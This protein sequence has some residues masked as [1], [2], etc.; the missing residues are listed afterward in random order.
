MVFLVGFLSWYTS[1]GIEANINGMVHPAYRKQGIFREILKNAI[2]DMNIKGVKT[3]RIKIPSNSKSGIDCIKQMGANFSSSEFSMQFVLSPFN[4]M[5]KPGLVLRSEEV[6]DFDFMVKCSSQAF[7]DS[8]CWTKN[9]FENTRE[10]E[11][12]TYIAMDDSIPIGMIRVN[13]LQDE[14]AVI[15]DFCVIPSYQVEDMVVKFLFK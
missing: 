14:T 9:Y 5:T 13:H 1:D 6:H 8:E 2:V 4:K 3:C 11:R 7:G 15:H 10:S 12:A